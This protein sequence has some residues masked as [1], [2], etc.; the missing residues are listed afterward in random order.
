MLSAWQMNCSG[1]VMENTRTRGYWGVKRV[2][3][4][5]RTLQIR[6]MASGMQKCGEGVQGEEEP[7]HVV[8]VVTLQADASISNGKLAD[9]W[10]DKEVAAGERMEAWDELTDLPLDPKGVMEAR[11]KELSYVEQKKM[12][13]MFSRDKAKENG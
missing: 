12:W 3:Q 1:S 9:E 10:H 7:M 6:T 4:W 11:Q 5:I 8:P 13:N 2:N